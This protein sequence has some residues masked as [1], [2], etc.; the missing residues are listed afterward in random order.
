MIEEVLSLPLER[1][2]MIRSTDKLWSI[3]KAY[4]ANKNTLEYTVIIKLRGSVLKQISL[5][6]DEIKMFKDLNVIKE[7]V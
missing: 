4:N 3:T 2:K 5:T 6:D 1:K 7:E